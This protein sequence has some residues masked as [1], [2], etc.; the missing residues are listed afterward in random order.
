MATFVLTDAKIWINEIDLSATS[1][2]LNLEYA[3]EALD[4]TAFGD[5]TRIMK[6]GLKTISLGIS[7]H[8]NEDDATLGGGAYNDELFDDVGTNNVL[9]GISPE[10]GTAGDTAYLFQAFQAN[11]N[12]SGG[13]GELL[14]F[15][16]DASAGDE[17]VLVR[18]TLMANLAAQTTTGSGSGFQLGAVSA[19][20]TLYGGLHVLAASAGDTLDVRIESDSSNSFSGAETTRMTFAQ[21]TAVGSEYQTVTG[22]ITDTWWR[23]DFTIAG[24]GPSYDFVVTLGIL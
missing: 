13:I 2:Q 16:I 12:I 19:S 1:N 5:A 22:A 18:G 20:Q 3:A 7:G 21:K 15:S 9:I 10:G 11:Y 23:T 24:A 4:E 6:G 17:G 8:F 14:A